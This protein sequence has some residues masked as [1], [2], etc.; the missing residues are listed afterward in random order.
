MTMQKDSVM[1]HTPAVAGTGETGVI[2]RAARGWVRAVGSRVKPRSSAEARSL[3]KAL[4]LSVLCWFTRC[5]HRLCLD[6]RNE[7]RR[8]RKTRRKREE[9]LTRQPVLLRVY[10][11]PELVL[12]IRQRLHPVHV[13]LSLH[14]SGRIVEQ[15]ANLLLASL[16]RGS[17]LAGFGPRER[18]LS[19]SICFRTSFSIAVGSAVASSVSTRIRFEILTFG[20]GGSSKPWRIISC[21]SCSRCCR[22]CVLNFFCSRF[23]SFSGCGGGAAPPSAAASAPGAPRAG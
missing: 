16:R 8:E 18:W 10:V 15:L 14:A 13:H 5:R 4:R 22:R 20:F 2:Q 3:L 1:R 23:V 6:P 19:L 21:F 12:R 9:A 7:R 17:C 11:H